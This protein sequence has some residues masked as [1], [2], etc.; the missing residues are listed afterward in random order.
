MLKF[1]FSKLATRIWSN[2]P[3]DFKFYFVNI[4][5]TGRYF[6]WPTMINWMW[7]Y[8]MTLDYFSSSAFLYRMPWIFTICII[9][10]VS[11]LGIYRNIWMVPQG[12]KVLIWFSNNSLIPKRMLKSRVT[13]WVQIS[14]L[15]IRGLN[16]PCLMPIRVRRPCTISHGK[17]LFVLPKVIDAY[18]KSLHLALFLSFSSTT[19]QNSLV[20]FGIS[21]HF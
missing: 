10:N 18:P 5:S 13:I 3:V 1:R 19:L 14:Q 17:D 9:C 12:T 15:I 20:D 16:P 11:F 8:W 2:F 21:F 6:L 4:S 7:T